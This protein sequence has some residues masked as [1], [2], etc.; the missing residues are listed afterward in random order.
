MKTN[1][2]VNFFLAFTLAACGGS[3]SEIYEAQYDA[4]VGGQDTTRNNVI[5]KY[6]V[7]IFDNSTKKYCTGL[8]IRKDVVLT[9]AHCVTQKPEDLTLAFGLAPLAGDYVMR[10]AARSYPHEAYKRDNLNNRNDLA[11]IKILGQAPEGYQPLQLP[12]ADFPIKAGL[13]F[14]A[15]GYGRVSGKKAAAA[16]T[17]GSGYLRNVDLTIKDFSPDENQFFVDQQSNKGIC[18]GDSGGPALMRLNG[19]DYVVGIASAISWTVPGEISSDAKKDYV[20]HKDICAEKSIYMNVK[21][22]YDWIQKQLKAL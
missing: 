1:L 11:L 19:I 22:Y 6:V 21:K 13:T 15:A 4:I 9:A 14:T 16:D 7:L 17:Q 12:K 20:D 2:Y 10:K 18:G 5:S 3:P 8:L